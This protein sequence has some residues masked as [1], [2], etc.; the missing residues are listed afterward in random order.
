MASNVRIYPL[1]GLTFARWAWDLGHEGAEI[2]KSKFGM[3]F[4]GGAEFDLSNEF[5]MN[6]EV[7]YQLVS[8][9]DQAIFSLGIAYMF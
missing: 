4:G 3:N 7:K 2:T 6:F 9:F 8:D 5:M 1:A